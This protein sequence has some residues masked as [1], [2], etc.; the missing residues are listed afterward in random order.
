M[1]LVPG[2]GAELD[3][4]HIDASTAVSCASLDPEREFMPVAICI[5]DSSGTSISAR[6]SRSL[7]EASIASVRLNLS[8]K[9]FD[10]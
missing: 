7:D 5:A 9:D 3:D 1:L 4:T 2:K 10:E 6:L 8:A